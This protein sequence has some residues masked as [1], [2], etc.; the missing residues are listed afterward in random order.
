[1]DEFPPL[2]FAIFSVILVVLLL[3]FTR[4]SGKLKGDLTRDLI[5][6]LK[7]GKMRAYGIAAIVLAIVVAANVTAL[8]Q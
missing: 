3:P 4:K 8:K 1:M 6:D 2:L 5:V 7:A